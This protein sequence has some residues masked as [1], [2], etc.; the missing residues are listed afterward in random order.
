MDTFGLGGMRELLVSAQH[1]AQRR[2]DASDDALAAFPYHGKWRKELPGDPKARAKAEDEVKRWRKSS[3]SCL[4]EL[5]AIV[6]I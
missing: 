1:V 3:F 6:A 4:S 2:H 5:N